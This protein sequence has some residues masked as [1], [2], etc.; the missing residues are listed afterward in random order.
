MTGCSST[1]RDSEANALLEVWSND[2]IQRQLSGSCR[3]EAV[4]CKIKAELAKRGVARGWE[5][6]HDKLKA[7]KKKYKEVVDGL[8][9]SGFA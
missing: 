8:R 4:Y 9:R 5:Q 3:N 6:C 1:G 7:L 2:T